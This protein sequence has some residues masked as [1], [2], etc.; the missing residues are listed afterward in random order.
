MLFL[1]VGGGR[2]EQEG[3]EGHSARGRNGGQS[4][5]S[6]QICARI[7]V[8][9]PGTCKQDLETALKKLQTDETY[10]KIKEECLSA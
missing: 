5:L 1:L 3:Q 4:G 8:A 2:G 7:S 10:L 9:V 6:W